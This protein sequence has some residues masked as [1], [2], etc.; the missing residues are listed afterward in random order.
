[1]NMKALHDYVILGLGGKDTRSVGGIFIP[2]DAQE[3]SDKCT[4]LAVGPEVGTLKVGDVVQKPDV[5]AVKFRKGVGFD[6]E[7][8]DGT[9]CITVKEEDVA[10]I[11]VE[12]D[13]QA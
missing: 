7:L 13:E 6:F 11:W 4:V 12:S 1:V 9:Q 3:V 10:V 8:P 2:A 5:T